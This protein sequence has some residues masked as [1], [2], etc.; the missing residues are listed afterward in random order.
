MSETCAF[1]TCD[2]ARR[3]RAGL[4]EAH[5]RQQDRGREL[6][7][8]GSYMARF[9][10]GCTVAGCDSPHRARGLCAT[11]YNSSLAGRPLQVLPGVKPKKRRSK[12]SPLPAG[13][14]RVSKPTAR[15]PIGTEVQEIPIAPPTSPRT[16]ARVLAGLRAAGCEDLADMLGVAPDQIRAEADRWTMWEGTDA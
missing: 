12:E 6:S 8:I 11:H 9:A 5:K 13:W 15:R 14:G 10:T 4:C 16:L 3:S 7:P 1:P 2:R